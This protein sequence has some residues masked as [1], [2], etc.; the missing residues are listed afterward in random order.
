[1]ALSED[2][3]TAATATLRVPRE[4]R[5]EIA[6]LAKLRGTSMVEVVSDAVN[7]LRI[8][9]WW[10]TVHDALDQWDATDIQEHEAE[11]TELENSAGDRLSLD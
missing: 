8:T 3:M 6:D 2:P 1:M 4:L 10:S 7:Q 5:D 11:V 9:E